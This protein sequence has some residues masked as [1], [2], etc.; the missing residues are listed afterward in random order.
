MAL[1]VP[2]LIKSCLQLVLDSRE[3]KQGW[4]KTLRHNCKKSPFVGKFLIAKLLFAAITCDHLCEYGGSGI[5]FCFLVVFFHQRK[6][7]CPVSMAA[8]KCN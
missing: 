3:A 7:Q 8:E 6:Q 4:E 1:I 5:L 2:P